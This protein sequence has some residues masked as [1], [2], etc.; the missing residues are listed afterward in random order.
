LHPAIVSRK[1]FLMKA[2]NDTTM[3]GAKN[4]PVTKRDPHLSSDGKWRSFPKVPNLLQYV[5]AG[6]YYARCKVNGKPVR[7]SLDTEVFSVAKLRLADKLKE[8]RKP[9]AVVGSF[10]DGR[11]KYESETANGYTSKKNR[12]VKLAPLSIT[13]RLRCLENLRRTLIETLFHPSKTWKELSQ[14]ARKDDFA[15]LDAM[16]ARDFTKEHCEAWQARYSAYAPSFFNNTVNTFR[17][18]L[19]LAGLP[20][21]DNPAFKIGRRDILEKPI[22]LPRPDRCFASPGR[23]SAKRKQRSGGTWTGRKT[24]SKF[25]P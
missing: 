2:T 15:K 24:R 14:Q 17:R 1:L 3:A 12:F 5:I 22:R 16:N 19:E 9:K 25:I 10:G 8:L 21:D 23:D 18:L 13:Y 4:V 7:A 11:L 6:T 20:H